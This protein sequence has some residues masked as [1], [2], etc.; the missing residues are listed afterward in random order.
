MLESERPSND[1]LHWTGLST[2]HTQTGA[3]AFLASD[4]AGYVNGT[5]LYVDG[6][7]AA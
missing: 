3:P 2:G 6:G 4:Q 5:T 7:L 1:H